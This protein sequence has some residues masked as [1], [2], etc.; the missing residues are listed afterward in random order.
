MSIELGK[1]KEF[2]ATENLQ[3][4]DA[5]QAS[6][7]AVSIL[8]R[9]DSSPSDKF[10]ARQWV[11][12]YAEWNKGKGQ[13]E[14]FPTYTEAKRRNQYSSFT[15]NLDNLGKLYADNDTEFRGEMERRG[16][17]KDYDDAVS[18]VNI[19]EEDL[20][21]AYRKRAFLFDLT[22]KAD[23]SQFEEAQISSQLFGKT[24]SNTKEFVQ[25]SQYYMDDQTIRRNN[26]NSAYKRGMEAFMDGDENPFD[27]S[28]M[29]TTPEEQDAYEKGYSLYKEGN[30]GKAFRFARTIVKLSKEQASKTAGDK[31]ADL[32]D[33]VT[34][35]MVNLFGFPTPEPEG[36][37]LTATEDSIA[38]FYSV[39]GG[40]EAY[41]FALN[42]LVNK[43]SEKLDANAASKFAAGV[44]RS[45]EDVMKNYGR[46][47]LER[48]IDNKDRSL[49]F[50]DAPREENYEIKEVT[51][52]MLD[53]T[54]YTVTEEVPKKLSDEDKK[55]FKAAHQV[56]VD[57][58]DLQGQLKKIDGSGW[59]SNMIYDN[60][61]TIAQL[62]FYTSWGGAA[63]MFH[64]ER[65]RG[66]ED[67]LLDYPELSETEADMLS[68][69]YAGFYVGSEK[70]Q[71]SFF[72]KP[73]R[74]INRVD[75]IFKKID[76][77]LDR[78][79]QMTKAANP[80][81]VM[82][83]LK[84]GGFTLATQL[85][86]DYL[87]ETFQEA[88]LPLTVELYGLLNDNIEGDWDQFK[89]WDQ[90][91]FL[92]TLPL[93]LLAAGGKQVRD[94]MSR[95]D[96]RRALQD[97]KMVRSFGRSAEQA[98]ELAE[99][100]DT[101]PDAALEKFKEQEET[102]P[103]EEREKLG[104]E[105]YAE[106]FR[107]EFGDQF[108]N[109]PVLRTLENGKTELRYE[110][111]TTEEYDTPEQANAGL[112][113]W[114]MSKLID[115]RE[116]VQA[117]T[118]FL[119]ERVSVAEGV[120][121]EIEE[122][123]ERI[124]LQ[125]LL[126]QGVQTEA[127]LKNAVAVY[128]LQKGEQAPND[129]DIDLSN[130]E[131][132]GW[133][134]LKQDMAGFAVRLSK[135]NN[136][137]VVGE[138]FAE[139]FIRFMV[140]KRQTTVEK[141]KEMLDD[142]GE[143]SGIEMTQGYELNPE[144]AITE[145]F[146]KFVKAYVLQG[147]HE[148]LPKETRKWLDE[149]WDIL[150]NPDSV[151][152][153]LKALAQL[154]AKTWAEVFKV[155]KAIKKFRAARKAGLAPS[156]SPTGEVSDKDRGFK[157]FE[158]LEGLA[159]RALGLD[160]ATYEA[161]LR[162]KAQKEIEEEVFDPKDEL[163]ER[164]KK[165]LPNPR[166]YEGK[167]K[168]ELQAI[169]DS[170]V[171]TDKNGKINK[172]KADNFFQ[173]KANTGNDQDILELIEELNQ[174][175]GFD[176]EGEDDFFAALQ[177]SVDYI[178]SDGTMGARQFPIGARHWNEQRQE[179]INNGMSFSIGE[180]V[181]QPNGN[182]NI[183]PTENGGLIGPAQID[184]SYMMDHRPTGG[185]ALTSLE[186]M[187][188]D[189]IYGPNAIRYYGV[190]QQGEDEAVDVFQR[191]RNKPNEP[192][193]LYRVVP[194][195][196]NEINPG[197]WVT[198]SKA[199]AEEMAT[200]EF[201]MADA[202]G[203]E[204][205]PK[206]L[207]K[208]VPAKEVF[209]PG[210]SLVEQ[211]WFPDGD[212]TFSIVGYHGTAANVDRFSTDKIGE[213]TA[214]QVFGYGLYFSNKQEV[215][216]L[217]RSSLTETL[218][219]W[220]YKGK[221]AS[222]LIEQGF[223][224]RDLGQIA[225][226]K[227]NE[228]VIEDVERARRRNQDFLDAAIRSVNRHKKLDPAETYGHSEILEELEKAAKIYFTRVY[229]I[230]QQL[231]FLQENP[232]LYKDLSRDETVGNIYR[233]DLGLDEENDLLNWGQYFDAQPE[234]VQAK[235]RNFL[236]STRIGAEILR[237]IQAD[238]LN[239]TGESI[240]K[241]LASRI[242]SDENT[243]QQNANGK[244]VSDRLLL[245]GI[246][247]IKYSGEMG[248]NNYV[249]FNDADIEITAGVGQAFEET[250]GEETRIAADGLIEV[251][252][253]NEATI[254]GSPAPDSNVNQAIDLDDKADGLAFDSL[255][256][257]IS[258][259]LKTNAYKEM[260]EF[261]A[262][263]ML[264]ETDTIGAIHI[265]RAGIGEIDGIPIQG[266]MLY[267]AIKEN[268]EAGI[269]WAFNSV[270][271]ARDVLNRAAKN[272][273]YI[274]LILM[275]E[276]N[277]VGN[278][279]FGLIWSNRLKEVLNT[280]EKL[281]TF[282]EEFHKVREAAIPL[283]IAD[284]RR[285]EKKAAAKAK[286]EGKTPEPP[287]AEEDIATYDRNGAG[288]K[289]FEEFQEFLLGMSQTSRASY[290]LKRGTQSAD[291]KTRKAGQTVY[292]KLIGET[293]V[294][295]HGWPDPVELV[296][297]MEDE[298]FKGMKKGDVVGFIKI[299]P[300][301]EIMTA[302]QAGV[303]EHLSYAY[304]VKGK[305]Y[306]RAKNI[307]NVEQDYP[308]L[309][310]QL[311]AQGAKEY[312]AVDYAT[313]SII[314]KEEGGTL[315][316]STFS[317]LEPL[318]YKPEAS[319]KTQ[320]TSTKATY[321][322]IASS[323]VEEGMTVLDYA[324]GLGAGT[325][326]AKAIGEKKGF[327]VVGYEPFSNPERRQTTPEYEGEGSNDLI[328]DGSVDVIINN[329]VLNVVPGNVGKA[330]VKDIYK[331]LRPGG[332]AFINV[333][334]WNN[335]KGRLKS[336]GTKLVGPREVLTSKGTFQKGYT[337]Q[338]LK[339]MIQRE[340]PRAEIVS[341]KYGDVGV[342]VTKPLATNYTFS[343]AEVTA[344]DTAYLDALNRADF[345]KAETM[346]TEAAKKKGGFKIFHGSWE[347]R[348]IAQADRFR[349]GGYASSRVVYFTDEENRQLSKDFGLVREYFYF[350]TKAIADIRSKSDTPE[351]RKLIKQ[352]N[353]RGGYGVLDGSHRKKKYGKDF[354][355]GYDPT[356]ELLD[357][358]DYVNAADFLFDGTYDAIQVDEDF[359]ESNELGYD[360]DA[361]AIIDTN[362]IK[363]AD[364]VTFD[365]NG[366]VIP[367][368]QRFNMGVTNLSFSIVEKSQGQNTLRAVDRLF[369]NS[370]NALET[371]LKMKERLNKVRQRYEDLK[372]KKDWLGDDLTR[373]DQIINALMQINAIASVLP[374]EVRKKVG[375]PVP[376]VSRKTDKGIEKQLQEKLEKV[377][378]A[379]DAYLQKT[380]RKKIKDVLKKSDPKIQN[381]RRTG[382][383]GAFGHDI[384][385]FIDSL[386][387]KTLEEAEAQIQALSDKFEEIENPTLEDYE[388]WDAQ[389]LAVDLFYDF[390]NATT[391][392]LE[393]A[394]DFVLL[395]Y[396]EGRKEWLQTLQERKE[397]RK[398]FVDQFIEFNGGARTKQGD[399]E[400]AEQK[401][402]KSKLGFLTQWLDSGHHILAKTVE[403]AKDKRKARAWF[404]VMLDEQIKNQVRTEQ[405][406]NK[407]KEDLIAKIAEVIGAEG[408]TAG[409]E[410]RKF[411]AEAKK[412]RPT[413]VTYVHGASKETISV[414]LDEAELILRGEK[415]SYKG[416]YFSSEDLYA[417]EQ[418][419]EKALEKPEQV[420]SHIKFDRTIEGERVPIDETTGDDRVGLSYAN[421]LQYW[422]TMR[423]EDQ[424]QKLEA[425]GWDADTKAELEA[426]LPDEIKE[427]GV[428]MSEQLVA[429]G[430]SIN[431]KHREE[432]G[433]SLALHDFYWPV[434]NV[435]S[436]KEADISPDGKGPNRGMS[437]GALKE[438]VRNLAKPASVNAFSVY[439]QHTSE[440]AY[441]KN[442]ISWFRQYG[443]AMRSNEFAETFKAAVGKKEYQEL[444][445]YLQS[446][447]TRGE[448]MRVQ[449][450]DYE[451]I[452][453]TMT[454]R[455]ALGVLGMRISTMWINASSFI[456]ALASPDVSMS[457]ILRNAVGMMFD[458]N[459]ALKA[460]WR[461][462]LS[463]LR[464]KYGASFEAQMAMKSGNQGPVLIQDA[465]KLAQL[466][467]LPMNYIDVGM[468]SVTYA[469]IWKEYYDSGIKRG[470][471]EAAARA[472]ADRAVTRAQAMLAQPSLG[473]SR[474]LAEQ[475]AGGNVFMGLM[476]LFMS[477]MR[478]NAANNYMAW[479]ALFTGKGLVDKP[480]AARQA[481][482]YTVINT[483][484][485]Q[486]MRGIFNFFRSDDAEDEELEQQL[487][488]PN[489]WIYSMMS[490]T[491]GA[492]P[493]LSDAV[494]F[495]TAKPLGQKYWESKN[496][497]VGLLQKLTQAGKVVD[498]DL[499]DSERLEA[500]LDQMQAAGSLFV[501]GPI[502]A[503][504]ANVAEFVH[505][506]YTNGLGNDISEKDRIKRFA[507]EIM[508]NRK[509]VY[510]KFED[511][512]DRIPLMIDVLEQYQA[513][514]P[515]QFPAILDE[516]KARD[517]ETGEVK[518][519]KS[520]ATEYKLPRE[521]M[522]HF[523]D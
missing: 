191:V 425:M 391:A 146:S 265:D 183:L 481:F 503:E 98:Q 270:S 348:K 412:I 323:E 458:G 290:Y 297:A 269:G 227:S 427:I 387:E 334:G 268:F 361:I 291:T 302:R 478:K 347:H 161:N 160:E 522:K 341:T 128:F 253:S 52:Y 406:S 446:I 112:E 440:M 294:K 72:T 60:V 230:D 34:D 264:A 119:Q 65:Q 175:Y 16:M 46:G 461:N 31:A 495:L 518:T 523:V 370:K 211:G 365:S 149:A 165:S 469:A 5:D 362:K 189:D 132:P 199:A 403:N 133:A 394:Y 343:I 237:E 405:E 477:E 234:G 349:P 198:I 516:L 79:K 426:F 299:D 82:Q 421:A 368:S 471:S 389:T 397:R 400:E 205:T 282:I 261:L 284:Q 221:S 54:P 447:E 329:A 360:R 249:V 498:E 121:I 21:N 168:G 314:P 352:F 367:L 209:W 150:K 177:Q 353:E 378:K 514:F 152:P 134:R 197:D 114:M 17:L 101:D 454:S 392:R 3:Q 142:F 455:F 459:G 243:I 512:D 247:G 122:S 140:A 48:S 57:H 224:M 479:R 452:I 99:I 88:A 330:I 326:E 240:Y 155:A 380:L 208:V 371:G 104:Q 63:A 509:D 228:K 437:S 317:S 434:R 51:K 215:A 322:K 519:L 364:L 439:F 206:I 520:G 442:N 94:S 148:G 344:Q 419:Y 185:V 499:T 11:R 493:F 36:K 415:D 393:Q 301:S 176:F 242:S 62:P 210:D 490:E 138:E 438:R 311:L 2:Y 78:I 158:D 310:G 193:T 411:L 115:T 32:F 107:E 328:P 483:A 460:T 304:V 298:S 374:P 76:N 373:D 14:L 260:N 521:I 338:T 335:I 174:E 510:E 202:E 443:T 71:T 207:E 464:R 383:I 487:R 13:K 266:G 246:K 87:Q 436:G 359:A 488:D 24:A 288:I 136:P 472:E 398:Q 102:M 494:L 53:G 281:D 280:Q 381:G 286:K 77:Q 386:Y 390:D 250:Q 382:V 262:N 239:H 84:S 232:D 131:A 67:L 154:F 408:K 432:Y 164:V 8:Q 402:Q 346:V 225:M 96:L 105:A 213:G 413:S 254:P 171:K 457:R 190:G 44:A 470:D 169:H 506:V 449:M 485:V 10:A 420:P 235:L 315:P 73:L 81:S 404:Y 196:V 451:E 453:R 462:E 20:K 194:D 29:G 407:K 23:T 116:A 351:L 85:T 263:Q 6:L 484:V 244:A 106:T 61:G 358:E 435:V 256:F 372:Y 429:D 345:A 216:E 308:S 475:R 377:S 276:G 226:A 143:L 214:A 120:D 409:H 502:I 248:A 186:E 68:Y 293:I 217:Y 92:A 357:D 473:V 337:S 283:K 418:A 259:V 333:M 49:F 300:D 30:Y 295:K 296:E 399:A 450:T 56:S 414:R 480:T 489:F 188:P 467:M 27:A 231:E 251:V 369:G 241:K 433:I 423:Q 203:N 486:G 385:S 9:E 159:Q 110:D 45:W 505:E 278:K 113:K 170:M 109:V 187:F 306:A 491:T 74:K 117:M 465:E 58:R 496:P 40:R 422:L 55:I 59:F 312:P 212:L 430:V 332:S 222:S 178:T 384:S 327:T 507:K 513:E 127:E 350:P 93:G 318:G 356:W 163:A 424:A 147:R 508:A 431:D 162:E 201:L 86:V 223:T 517:S 47:M 428:W 395:N 274:K 108:D 100:A 379:L 285:K 320:I 219:R 466:G 35:K 321:K 441:W 363:S 417:L 180:T 324:A 463:E 66:K 339:E 258:P 135:G 18:S 204:Q 130:F 25:F 182:T 38:R 238:P 151:G 303:S 33:A 179:W 325:L 172:K 366:K 200:P 89:M 218:Q 492:L 90:R 144:R 500:L 277:V 316:P 39:E 476:T 28:K 272:N 233:V 236:G 292:G 153:K 474:S 482:V 511:S 129:A 64:S 50:P 229:R 220:L 12:D 401:A 309:T 252:K 80:L 388:M 287:L 267:P 497:F 41:L 456:N 181:V 355:K 156:Q 445:A 173:T 468:G 139:G 289:T 125:D 83:N 157:A 376:V 340:L 416:E 271:T 275:A 257:G 410:V 166:F 313:F 195:T 255:T 19:P 75:D 307:R 245:W 167:W 501:G 126:D 37:T 336:E 444:N 103:K 95:A 111:G 515:D 123:T 504:A 26:I 273:G 342:K 137:L 124:T 375:S 42:Y 70:L 141:M 331:K 4:I 305:P 118:G 448:S 396:K 43:E 184:L 192:V 15:Q 22:G 7:E 69:V 91:R 319:E 1:S 145:G 354:V 97:E 279:T